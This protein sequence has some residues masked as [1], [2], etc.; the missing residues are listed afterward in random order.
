M[1]TKTNDC[2][3]CLFVFSFSSMGRSNGDKKKVPYKQTDKGISVVCFDY[4]VDDL[5][6]TITIFSMNLFKEYTRRDIMKQLNVID[7]KRK[8]SEKRYDF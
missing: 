8:K 5:G 1:I 6:K 3:F 7:E 2:H 4:S